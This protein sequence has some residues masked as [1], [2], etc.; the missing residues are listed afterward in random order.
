MPA[1]THSIMTTISSLVVETRKTIFF[2]RWTSP[3]LP[4]I[5]SFCGAVSLKLGFWVEFLCPSPFLCR[6]MLQKN[7]CPPFEH[8]LFE[9]QDRQSLAFSS[10]RFEEYAAAAR[11]LNR[12]FLRNPH[13]LLLLLLV[14]VKHH[15]HLSLVASRLHVQN[16]CLADFMSQ[17]SSWVLTFSLEQIIQVHR[18]LPSFIHVEER[19]YLK[20]D[21]IAREHWTFVLVVSLLWEN[22]SFFWSQPAYSSWFL[23]RF[24]HKEFSNS[25][26]CLSNTN[27]EWSNSSMLAATSISANQSLINRGWV[28]LDIISRRT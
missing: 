14:D 9:V 10:A 22:W 13:F 19:E 12:S 20:H 27:P 8:D 7:I 2:S 25:I 3:Y 21:S 5:M 18:V 24:S 15:S 1:I 4:S 28:D 23:W 11:S 17:R 26:W 6:V 16:K